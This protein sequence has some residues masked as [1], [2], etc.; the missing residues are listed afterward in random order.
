MC[1]TCQGETSN[2]YCMQISMCAKEDRYCVTIKDVVGA[3]SGYKPKNRISKMCSPEC[4]K[5]IMKQGKTAAK[6]FCCDK[7]LCN[8][9]GASSMEISYSMIS[10]GILANFIYI[11]RSGL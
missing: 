8:V 2:K 7:L 6:V 11:F 10:M 1:Y 9:N 4:P 3:G 5:T